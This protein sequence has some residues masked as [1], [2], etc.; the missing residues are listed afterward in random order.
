[1]GEL[2][3]KMIRDIKNRGL[4]DS[5]VRN[6]ILGVIRLIKYWRKPPQE[7]TLEE[8][9]KYQ[10]HLATGGL[11]SAQTVNLYMAGIKFLYLKTLDRRWASNSIPHMK[12]KRPLPI[13]LSRQQVAQF[14]NAVEDIKYRALLTL[15]YSAGLR[16]SEAVQV[17]AKDI[18]TERHQI[19]VR[20][21]KG[22]KERFSI[23][24]DA[25]LQMLR[26]Y[27]KTSTEC[28]DYYLFPGRDP[29]EPINPSSVRKVLVETKTKIGLHEKFKVHSL[30]HTFATHLLEGG[31]DIRII[32][33]LLGH[34]TISSTEIYTHLR[35]LQEAGIK[36]PLDAIVE[37]LILT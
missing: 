1:M 27:W 31:V 36:N 10:F 21:G 20:K 24:S 16:V 22:G 12:V 34:S 4:S 37:K 23:L 32:Q 5:T 30:R 11:L 28:K 13:I 14:L 7:I 6:Y 18:L 8:I 33:I 26:N 15:I 25:L 19:H 17:S 3:E 29:K 9:Q 2:K 35:D